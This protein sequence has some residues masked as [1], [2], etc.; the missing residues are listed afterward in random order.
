MLYLNLSS[1][2]ACLLAI[3]AVI[4]NWI[5]KP[6]LN[7]SPWKPLGNVCVY[8][9]FQ[10]LSAEDPGALVSS[11][12]Q[13]TGAQVSEGRKR[14]PDTGCQYE[15][16]RARE[17][18]HLG[19][20]ISFATATGWYLGVPDSSLQ[21]EDNANGG[22]CWLGIQSPSPPPD[23]VWVTTCSGLASWMCDL[24]GHVGPPAPRPPC[25]VTCCAIT[26]LKFLIF[27]SLNLWFVSKVWWES[28]VCTWAEEIQHHMPPCSRLLLS[29]R[30]LFSSL[31][32]GSLKSDQWEDF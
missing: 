17:E 19:L 25:L 14:S 15:N 8:A 2:N 23:F 9:E 3:G 6:T 7:D 4:T 24:C 11:Q 13:A 20:N 16:G 26:I 28:G 18:V 32:S 21:N 27:V 1:F 5:N 10:L 29:R 12:W 30:I 31:V 22:Q